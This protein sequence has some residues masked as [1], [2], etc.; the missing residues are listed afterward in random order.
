[1]DYNIWDSK[2]CK[3][4]IAICIELKEYMQINIWESTDLSYRYKDA[5]A[6]YRNFLDSIELK[7]PLPLFPYDRLNEDTHK[8]LEIYFINPEWVYSNIK[9]RKR[10]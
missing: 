5:L 3:D 1:M 8:Y 6:T 7:M 2:P 9:I 4:F 10:K